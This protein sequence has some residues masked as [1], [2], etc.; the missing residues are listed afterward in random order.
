MTQHEGLQVGDGLGG[1]TE[2]KAVGQLGHLITLPRIVP[3][4]ITN[5]CPI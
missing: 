5:R 2:R 1:T 4:P 3:T